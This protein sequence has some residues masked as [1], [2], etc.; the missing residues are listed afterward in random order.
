MP[1]YF[2]LVKEW[3]LEHSELDKRY[4]T[5]A[6]LLYLGQYIMR[7]PP[8][9]DGVRHAIPGIVNATL[10]SPAVYGRQVVAALGAVKQQVI[11]ESDDEGFDTHEVEEFQDAAFDGANARLRRKRLPLL[12]PF[13]DAQFCFRGRTGRRILFREENGVLIPDIM[14]LDGRYIR[15]KMG[16]EDL[17]WYGYSTK[18]TKSEIEGE[19]GIVIDGKM[20]SVL[21]VWDKEHNEVWIDGKHVI[22]TKNGKERKEKHNYGYVPMVLGIVPLGY[23]DMLLDEDRLK[24]EGE[25]IF[26]LIRGIVPQLNMVISIGQTL[27][28]LSVKRPIQYESKDGQKESPNYDEVMSP[29]STVE[30][31]IGGG[32]KPIDFG[33]AIGAFD[34]VYNMLEKARQEGSYTDIDIGNVRQ[35]FSAVALIEIGEGRNQPLLPILAA[36]EG[37]NIDSA[38]MITRQ[39]IQIGGTV[40]LGVPGHK[41]DFGTSKLKGE[42]TTDY[43]YFIKSPKIDIARISMAGQ[44]KEWYPRRHIYE[45]TLQ[46]ED[47]DGMLQEWYSDLAEVVDPNVLKLRIVLG[48]LAKADDGDEDA[49]ME[50]FVM[51]QGMNI[52][53]EQIKAGIIPEPPPLPQGE[54]AVPLLPE[55]GRVGGQIPSSAKKA[56]DLSR[57]PKEMG[58]L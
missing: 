40:E 20:G 32:I 5:D 35:P 55:G 41:R 57:T 42:Y 44:A 12:N 43:K 16:E 29:G 37:L 17:D 19:Y 31:E 27:N 38:E 47:P 28:F 14:P 56:S 23:G 22:V 6:D 39:V 21:D 24:N 53:I 50:A 11:V 52:S 4:Q 15:Y 34:R 3:E 10:N 18:R 51:A 26:Y 49:E 2:E 33:D 58:A 48:L 30:A 54:P 13:A 46:V 7:S 1:N 9:I 8:D 25:S 36:K 45:E